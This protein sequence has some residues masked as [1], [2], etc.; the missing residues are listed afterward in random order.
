[1]AAARTKQYRR[2][3]VIDID[4]PSCYVKI[5]TIVI[6][7]YFTPNRNFGP[8]TEG[9]I[10]ETELERSPSGAKFTV[11]EQDK[12]I[13]WELPFTGLNAASNLLVQAMLANNGVSKALIFCTD[14]TAANANSYWVY[15]KELSLPENQHLGE[16]VAY[17]NWTASLEEVV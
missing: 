1:M 9:P 8:Y 15:F 7:K 14:S 2:V 10:D 4:N 13:N 17:W 3:H 11:Q 5:G 6:G 12:L 16:N